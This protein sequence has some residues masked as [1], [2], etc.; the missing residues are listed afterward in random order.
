MTSLALKSVTDPLLRT[1]SVAFAFVL[2]LHGAAWAAGKPPEIQNRQA[3]RVCADPNNL[4]YSNRR[5]EGFE[6]KIAIM[7]AEELGVPLVYVWQPQ[8]MGMHWHMLS[9]RM[10]D[11]VIG[12]AGT[13]DRVQSTNPYYTSI[14]ALVYG[15]DLG[16][17]ITS[18]TDTRLNGRTIGIIEGTPP[19][20]VL[21]MSGVGA[22]IKPYPLN[23]DTRVHTPAQKAIEDVAAGRS[24]AA[25][26]WGPLAVH[27]ARQQQ[28]PL[29]V[30]PLV[31][32]AKG[33]VRLTFPIT[34]GLRR[35]EPE[36]RHWLN[37][38]L[39]KREAEIT[40]LLANAGVPLVGRDGKLID[41]QRLAAMRLAE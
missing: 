22:H 37:R 26:L 21:Q 39:R 2:C 31:D 17:D 38:F 25:A 40:A 14:Y 32:D 20:T 5:G 33:A 16:S 41:G 19:A 7:I 24:D 18:L 30:V 9:L 27:Y 12:V 4:P 34:M 23:A 1:V 3:L 29:V 28:K 13:F 10:C 6:N 36:W 11:L 8:V 35:N 15:K